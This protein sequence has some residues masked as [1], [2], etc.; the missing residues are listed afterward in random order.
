MDACKSVLDR[1]RDESVDTIE[2]LGELVV[3][4]LGTAP[5]VHPGESTGGC[6]FDAAEVMAEQSCDV[7]GA[8]VALGVRVLRLP[9]GESGTLQA[10]RSPLS[11]QVPTHLVEQP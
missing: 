1:L 5:A 3:I 7:R 2:G 11:G 9:L 6:G 10:R 8:V 4:A